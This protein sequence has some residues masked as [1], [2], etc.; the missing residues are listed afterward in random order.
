MTGSSGPGGDVATAFDAFVLRRY[1]A[2]ARFGYVLTGNR[3]S[4]EDLVQTALFRTY[5]RWER[6]E[7]QS[8]PLAYVRRAMVNAHISWT[9]LH[10]SREQLFADPPEGV[11]VDGGDLDRVHMWRQLG[12]LPPRMRAVLVLRYYEDLSEIETARVLGCSVGTVKSQTHRG[13]ARLRR[14][15]METDL[16]RVQAAPSRLRPRR[17]GNSQMT[18]DPLLAVEK[19]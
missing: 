1:A 15:L 17:R 9:R 16:Q 18:N 13:L 19:S 10:S 4:A 2:L 5:R 11:A 6:L 3:A 14:V 8:D 7:D 12:T